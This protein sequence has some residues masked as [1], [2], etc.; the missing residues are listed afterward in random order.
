MC[1][2]HFHLMLFYTLS[3]L[4]FKGNCFTPTPQNLFYNYYFITKVHKAAIV[5]PVNVSVTKQL[6]NIGQHAKI[7]RVYSATMGKI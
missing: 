5:L 7:P 2:E 4:H 1:T 3:P 6:L